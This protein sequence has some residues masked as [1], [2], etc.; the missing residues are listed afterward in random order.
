MVTVLLNRLSPTLSRTFLI[1]LFVFGFNT[2]SALTDFSYVRHTS[3]PPLKLLL[4]GDQAPC[5]RTVCGEWQTE[6]LILLLVVVIR[7][8]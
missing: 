1:C 8:S 7:D 4:C 5:G 2:I 6:R 3:T